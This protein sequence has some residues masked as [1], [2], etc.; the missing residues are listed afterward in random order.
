[1]N[2]CVCVCVC[3]YTYINYTFSSSSVGSSLRDTA[4]VCCRV[5]N[6]QRYCRSCL[7]SC[8]AAPVSDKFFGGINIGA[9]SDMQV[10]ET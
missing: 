3:V 6:S 4:R 7:A 8:S 5:S 1:M 9:T 2:E 10:K